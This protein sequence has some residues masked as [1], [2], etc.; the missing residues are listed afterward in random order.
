VK[1]CAHEQYQKMASQFDV[2]C[3]RCLWLVQSI[4]Q[5]IISYCA[6]QVLDR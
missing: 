6:A 5:L 4:N 2:R 1:K 3:A